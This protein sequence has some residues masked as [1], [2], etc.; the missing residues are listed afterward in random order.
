MEKNADLAPVFTMVSARPRGRPR[1]RIARIRKALAFLGAA[2]LLLVGALAV[3]YFVWKYPQWLSAVSKIAD[4]K[5]RLT[6]ENE[7]LKNLFQVIGGAFLLVGIY[8]TWKNFF[9]ARE[10]QVTDRFNKAVELLGND[11]LEVRLG[12]IYALARIAKESSKDYWPIMQILCA[13]LRNNTKSRKSTAP[14]A[15]IQGV[16]DVLGG[17]YYEFET[18]EQ[19]LDLTEVDLVGA[20]LRG[21]FLERARFDGANL[22]HADFMGA[23]LVHADFR[24]AN[25]RHAHLRQTRLDSANLVGADLQEASLRL[26]VL[27]QANLLGAKMRDA[28]LV[29]AD[30]TGAQFMTRDQIASAVVDETTRMPEFLEASESEVTDT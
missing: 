25:L 2:L 21:A 29:G 23:S 27:R 30:L 3:V 28:T 22:E 6:L 14:S 1:L 17:R 5:D 11:K 18:V 10:G 15:D 13:Y 19:Y 8:F 4:T 12:G 16:L 20:N 24:G 7:L 26:A 9:L